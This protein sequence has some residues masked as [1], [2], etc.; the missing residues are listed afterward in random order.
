MKAATP[1]FRF[2]LFFFLL[3][4]LL[5]FLPPWEWNSG[6]RSHGTLWLAAS[7]LFARS[8]WIGLTAATATV[9]SIALACLAMGAIWRVWGTAYIG[10]GVMRDPVMQADRFVPAGPYRYVRNP[11]YLGSWLLAVGVS[12]L[13][14]PSGAGLFLLA[15]SIFVLFL[16]S[17]EERFLSAKLGDVYQQ[18][19]RHVPRLLPRMG[20]GDDVWDERPNWVRAILAETYPLAFTLCYAIFAWRYNARVLIQ[21]LL[22]CYGFSLV[23]RALAAPAAVE[24]SGFVSR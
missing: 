6:N 16:I 14:P 17:A 8:G 7:T 23:M 3:L 10:W 22:I 5:G 9:T 15:F 1:A 4:Y 19:R 20:A 21:C 18:Y 13:M 2:R 12:I 24:S 11:L